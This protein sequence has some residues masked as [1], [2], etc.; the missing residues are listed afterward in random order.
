MP[1]PRLFV[2][3]HGE[4]EWSL[5]GKHTGETDV[6]L[7]AA[8]ETR[9]TATA[10]AMIGE[11][12]K[13]ITPSNLA[14]VFVSPRTRARRTLQLLNVGGNVPVQVTDAVREWTYGSYEGLTSAQ[15]REKN[16]DWDIWR[17]GCPGGE[18]PGQIKERLDAFIEEVREGFHRPVFEGKKEKGDVLVVAHG[19]IL[20]AL[21]SRWVGQELGTTR[22]L[23]EPGGVGSLSY[24]HDD[25][26]QPGLVL[27]GAFA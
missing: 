8:G 13:L 11:E 27:G 19:H 3:R 1:P 25:I 12:G 20:R 15:I 9:I 2:V 4:T 23:L 14:Q 24:E 10:A 21:A 16:P 5:S 6:P 22:L 17:D 26:K 7:T 18:S